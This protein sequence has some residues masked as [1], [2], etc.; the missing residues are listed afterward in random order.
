MLGQHAPDFRDT[1]PAFVVSGPEMLQT[2]RES[3]QTEA[4]TCIL[5]GQ[6]AAHLIHGGEALL[7]CQRQLSSRSEAPLL[8]YNHLRHCQHTIR[9]QKSP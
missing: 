3:M 9:P 4:S 6:Q 8:Q 1:S 5:G 7:L 2:R